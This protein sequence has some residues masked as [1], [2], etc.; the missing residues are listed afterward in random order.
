MRRNDV[1]TV[2]RA[3]ARPGAGAP[4]CEASVWMKGVLV[5]VGMVSLAG[6][7]ACA[8]M[9]PAPTLYERF[10]AVDGVGITRQGRDAIGIVVESFVANMVADSRV[11][12]RFK[13]LQ[14]AARGKLTSSL[15]DQLCE[16]AGGPCSYYGK[17]MKTTHKGMKITEAEWNAT[18]E[19]MAKA[20]D[21]HKV[22][23]REK[24]ELLA[25]LGP[26][27]ADIVGQ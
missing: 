6:L 16:A 21:K 2:V 5:L 7:A 3:A 11:N 13:D 22:A 8:T 9:Q 23:E 1:M 18:V 19:N 10:R 15:A 26:M 27:K 24:K 25:A 4:A 20:L 17:D 14:P 12:A